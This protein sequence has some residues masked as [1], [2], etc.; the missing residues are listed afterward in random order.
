MV[1][2]I[3]DDLDRLRGAAPG[4]RQVELLFPDLNGILRGKRCTLGEF[5]G[6]ARDGLSFPATGLLLDSRGMLIERLPHGSEDGDPDYRCRPVPGSLTL[7]PWARGALAQVLMSMEDGEG[8]SHFADSRAVLGRVLARLRALGLRPVVAVEYEFYLLD[9]TRSGEPRARR[10]RVPGTERRAAGPRAYSLEDLHELDDLFADIASAGT[11]QGI[12]C[13]SIVSEYGA[14]QFEV[15]LHHVD[16]ALLACDHAVLLRRL[17]RGVAARHKLA[18]TFMAKPFADTDGSGMHVHV[19][20]LD[21]QG[22]NVFAPAEGATVAE[23]LRHAIGGMLAAL[24]ES[25]AIFCPNANSYR[26]IRP[27]CFAPVAPNWG[28]NHR[29][30]A[31]RIPVADPAN[32]RFEHR[33]AGADCNPYFAVAAILAA[34]HHGITQQIEPPPMVQEGQSVADAVLLAP[35]WEQALDAFDA[36]RLL[37]DYLGAEFCAVFSKARRFEA[38]EFHAQVS[39]LDYDW[40]LG[41]I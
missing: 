35:R 10:S 23:P 32:T 29:G 12:P 5:R 17:I 33:P 6:I 14:G 22:R 28:M 8:K 1:Q 37:P 27:G 9:D 16:D 24:P 40:Y 2:R 30:V 4:L 38:D 19:S 25:Q 7:V 3:L 34:A 31:L 15:N 36:G 39:N 20:L 41:A 11:A 18:A 21:A 26:R 13:G